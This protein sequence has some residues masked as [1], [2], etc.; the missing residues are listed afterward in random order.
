VAVVV[1]DDRPDQMSRPGR[2]ERGD[3][4]EDGDRQRAHGNTRY[5]YYGALVA[6]SHRLACMQSDYLSHSS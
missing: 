2:G 6:A 1:K 4:L 3:P 5:M